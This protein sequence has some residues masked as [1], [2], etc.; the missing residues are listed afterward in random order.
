MIDVW[1]QPVKPADFTQPHRKSGSTPED[2]YRSL[3]L[4][5]DG[6]PMTG[7]QNLL[8]PDTLWALVAH[9]L[10]LSEPATNKPSE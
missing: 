5:L 3:A 1:E 2:L 8:P 9:I 6:T 4:G 10:S 7:Y